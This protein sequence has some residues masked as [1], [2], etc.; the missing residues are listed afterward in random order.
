MSENNDPI[1]VGLIGCGRIAAVHLRHLRTMPG[2]RVVGACDLDRERARAFG[3]EHGIEE[4]FGDAAALL[5]LGVDAVHV[6]TPP[7]THADTA[8]V[9]LERGVHVLVEK[10]MATTAAAA[11]RMQAA[12]AAAGRLL[13]VDHNRLFDPVIA[14]AREL[15][16]SGALGTIVSAEAYQGVNVQEGGPAAAPLAMWLN[17]A[18]HPLYL[19]RAFIG[20]VADWHAFAGPLGELRAVLRGDRALGYLCFSPGASPYLNALSLHGTKATLHIDL[21]TMTLLRQQKRRLPSM[22]AK[23][24]LNVDQA[25]QLL[26]STARTTLAVAMRRMG[27]YPGIGEVIRRFHAAVATRSEAPVTADDGVAVVEL[28]EQ[29]WG[30]THGAVAPRKRR[31]STAPAAAGP[32]VLVTG[33]TGF[34]GRHVAAALHAAGYRV[35]AM[36]RFPG[37]ADAL[38]DVEEVTATLGDDASIAAAVAGAHAVV[39]CAAR[40]ARGGSRDDFFRD[41]VTGTHHLLVAARAAGVARFVHVSSIAVYGVH[42]D[43]GPVGEQVDYD[44]HPERRGAYT[45]SKLE[46]DRLV[47]EASR[48][49]SG[50]VV[51]RPGILVGADGPPFTARLCLGRVRGRTVIVGRGDARLP[52]CHVDDAARAAVLAVRAPA[53]GGAY[54]LVDETLTQDG[55]LRERGAALRPLYVPPLLAALPA[56][57]LEL[58]WRAAG[59]GAPALSRYKIRRATESIRY[60]TS[61]AR[62]DLGWEPTVGVCGIGQ[63]AGRGERRVRLETAAARLP[64]MGQ[65]AS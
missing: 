63:G 30:K 54:N 8:I 50:I 17:L 48:N 44:P 14:Q 56:L 40:V 61:R 16:E 32:I 13:C 23:A 37:M 53:A 7:V 1:R 25:T 49:G 43:A 39:H 2:V 24:A 36:V 28:L 12:A 19:L 51:L 47:R 15:V 5:G 57:A 10:P 60:D 46:A 6:L 18:P 26:A 11:R 21:N 59:R 27:T 62:R 58:V 42:Q 45:W 64:A 3:Q 4:T 41:N 9:A 65:G 55:W 34:L 31:A 22:F 38:D 29:I 33:A 52:L 35:R 20:D